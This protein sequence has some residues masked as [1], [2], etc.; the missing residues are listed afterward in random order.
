MK[1]QGDKLHPVVE[2][3]TKDKIN[4]SNRLGKALKAIQEKGLDPDQIFFGY[5]QPDEQPDGLRGQS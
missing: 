1:A 3:I 4:S 5:K 2:T